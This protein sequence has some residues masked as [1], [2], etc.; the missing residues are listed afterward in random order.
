MSG[1]QLHFSFFFGTEILTVLMNVVKP[2]YDT[3]DEE[4]NLQF[5]LVL[6]LSSDFDICLS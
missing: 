1:L 5:L 2:Q 6:V 3:Q 4:A